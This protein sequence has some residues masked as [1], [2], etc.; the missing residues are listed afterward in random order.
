MSL[1]CTMI[2]GDCPDERDNRIAVPIDSFLPPES[3]N[4]DIRVVDLFSGAGGFGLGFCLAG[5]HLQ[6]AVERDQWAADTLRQNHT[7]TNVIQED[8]RALSALEIIGAF[9]GVDVL[10]GGPPCQGFSVANSKAKR[11]LDPR[12]SLFREFI[13]VAELIKPTVLLLENVPGLIKASVS[14]NVSVLDLIVSE[15][16]RLGYFVYHRVLYAQDFGVPQI[17]PRLFVLGTLAEWTDPFPSETHKSKKSMTP[18]GCTDSERWLKPVSTW[19]AISDLPAVKAREGEEIMT[20]SNPP[21]NSFQKLLRG[22]NDSVYN[23]K[24][25]RHS[26][27]LIRRFLQLKWGESGGADLSPEFGARRRGFPDELSG[28]IYE[29][30][31]R[32]MYPDRPCHT[33]PAS[34]YANFVHPYQPRNFTPREGARIQ[35][36]PDWWIF[37]GRSNVPSKKLLAR[38]GRTNESFLCQYNQIGNAVPP[39]LAFH[40]A[41]HI[42]KK[43]A[44]YGRSETRCNRKSGP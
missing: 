4:K 28:K 13:R 3:R 24:P 36:F 30:N 18:G 25:M 1:K 35:S 41:R 43:I 27:R 23:H 15:Y 34:F 38:E 2:L 21:G 20:Y 44:V 22:K 40:L 12:N 11:S 9:K 31:N 7:N 5:A 39:L 19:E 29:Q 14:K 6:A 16:R 17:R 10:I 37:K 32:R 26:E 42:I 33:L 8:I